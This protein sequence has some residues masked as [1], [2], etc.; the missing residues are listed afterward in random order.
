M[1]TTVETLIIGGGQAGLALSQILTERGREN[2]ILERGD[3]VAEAWRSRAWDSF[4]LVTPN[5]QLRLPGAEYSGDEPDAFASRDDLVAFLEQYAARFALPIRFGVRATAVERSAS[6]YLVTTTAG[7]FEAQNVVVAT[8]TFQQPRVPALAAELPAG[9][10]QL[11]SSVYRS[12]ASLPPGA[13]LVVGSGQSGAQIAE[14]LRRSGRRVY[15]SVGRSGRLPRRYRGKDTS[16][17]LSQMGFYE[18]TVD[19]LPSPAARFASNAHVT[20]R[21]GGRT[22]NLHQLARDGVTLLGRVAGVQGDRLVI[23]PDLRESLAAADK[24]EADIVKAVDGYIEQRGIAAPPEQLP[25]L[26]D[27]YAV[28]QQEELSLNDAGVTSMIWAT[29]YAFDFGLVK[30]PVLDEAGY[31]IQQRGV[32][33]SPGL[34]FLGLHWLHNIKSGLLYGV[35]DD[36]AYLASVITQGG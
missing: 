26:Q 13:V 34:Y 14:E 9:V 6:G 1:K 11:H 29:G 18:R 31:P 7:A 22:L 25:A 19:K 30:L 10:L 21:D 33:S 8:G 35:G 23:K 32:T 5:W 28:E 17:W 4:T 24:F 16:A 36:A 27:G 12:P 2:L 3:R 15:L 20:G